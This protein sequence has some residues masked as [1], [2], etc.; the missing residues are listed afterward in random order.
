MS[1]DRNG[2]G[3]AVLFRKPLRIN[4]TI[5]MRPAE[6]VASGWPQGCLFFDLLP[7]LRCLVLHDFHRVWQSL[8]ATGQI[9]KNLRELRRWPERI[10]ASRADVHLRRPRD[11]PR[12]ILAGETRWLD[13]GFDP[14]GSKPCKLDVRKGKTCSLSF[15]CDTP[16]QGS[17]SQAGRLKPHLRSP[18]RPQPPQGRQQPRGWAPSARRPPDQREERLAVK[19]PRGARDNR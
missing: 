6:N 2:V 17:S 7:V 10:E 12:W 1:D 11:D 19:S 14:K 9:A 5:L 16:H 3:S 13:A 4:K 15:Y 8:R 18:H